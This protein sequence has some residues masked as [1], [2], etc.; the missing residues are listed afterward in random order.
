MPFV[1]VCYCFLQESNYGQE[2]PEF[3]FYNPSL[4]IDVRI[5]DLISRLTLEEKTDQMKN[6]KKSLW[7]PEKLQKFHFS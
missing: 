7:N 1:I 4:S 3:A 6:I 5:Q 2:L